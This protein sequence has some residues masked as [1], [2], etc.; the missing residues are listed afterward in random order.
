MEEKKHPE[1]EEKRHCWGTIIDGIV[2][3]FPMSTEE[4]DAYLKSLQEENKNR[5]KSR[6]AK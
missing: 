4:H 1:N 2:F 6:N 5:K 3:P